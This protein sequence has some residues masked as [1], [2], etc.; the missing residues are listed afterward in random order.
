MVE[1]VGVT[2]TSPLSA[3]VVGKK[4]ATCGGQA[5]KYS[6]GILECWSCWNWRKLNGPAAT[7]WIEAVDYLFSHDGGSGP[8]MIDIEQWEKWG[9]A[10]EML[11]SLYMLK[12][13]RERYQE[14]KESHVR[15]S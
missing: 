6:S 15:K 5:E 11:F 7:Y 10:D 9:I 14:M 1:E 3:G 8:D 13:I 4:C 12:D 2:R